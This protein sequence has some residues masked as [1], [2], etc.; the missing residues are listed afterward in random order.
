MSSQS[1]SNSMMPQL[2]TAGIEDNSVATAQEGVVVTFVC[3][4]A[5]CPGRWI[6][7]IYNQYATPAP[8]ERPSKK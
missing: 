7:P 3:G 4:E 1:D 5:A 2:R 6:S 8:Q